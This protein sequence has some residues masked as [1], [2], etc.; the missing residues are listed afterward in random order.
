MTQDTVV[1]AS[2]DINLI[3]R[4]VNL[5]QQA[6]QKQVVEAARSYAAIQ[7]LQVAE[8]ATAEN[9]RLMTQAIGARV[10]NAS[11]DIVKHQ[12]HVT[13]MIHHQSTQ[14]SRL[15]ECLS[16]LSFTELGGYNVN[17]TG[18]NLE[19]AI[20]P[21]RLMNAHLAQALETATP[22][23]GNTMTI[24]DAE[25]FASEV[26][27]LLR[28]AHYSCATRQP[29]SQPGSPPGS[30]QLLDPNH[31]KVWVIKGSPSMISQD[32]PGF[33]AVEYLEGRDSEGRR[34]QQY[35]FLSF[36]NGILG[37]SS[38]ISGYLTHFE[39][40][41]SSYQPSIAR[42]LSVLNVVS[43]SS[44]AF[45]CAS[46]ND[47]DRLRNLFTNKAASPFDFD[48]HGRSLLAVGRF[49]L[50][51]LLRGVCLRLISGGCIPFSRRRDHDARRCRS[52]PV[53]MPV[54]GTV[55]GEPPRAMNCSGT[56]LP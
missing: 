48:E 35:R 13:D 28:Y 8:E 15:S 32:P 47:A 2:K 7:K 5:I 4:E 11:K 36:S 29:I 20:D 34:T 16:W 38:G 30:T 31:R 55:S 9:T 51:R 53:H 37:G 3:K 18:H 46:N 33:L 52:R 19:Q 49:L 6:A 25:W 41:S 39:G 23:N 14:I 27:K 17:V 43:S 12:K 44:E 50:V 56:Y 45:R 40:I 42:Q 24:N 10:E 22:E 26:D 54:W 21:L 1:E